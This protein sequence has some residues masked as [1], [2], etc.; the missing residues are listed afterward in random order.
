MK[1]N[2]RNHRGFK[3][4]QA[5]KVVIDKNNHFNG[6]CIIKHE[7]SIFV[8][9]MQGEV[10]KGFAY[11]T[12]ENGLVFKGEYDEGKKVQGS[13]FNSSMD[14]VI[15]EGEWLN[16]YYHGRGRL[17]CDQNHVY[18]G[19]FK[20][21]LFDGQGEMRWSNGDVYSGSFIEHTRSG[22]GKLKFANGD[23]YEGQFQLGKPEGKGKYKWAHGAE[24]E[25]NFRKG[26]I[27]TLEFSTL[28]QSGINESV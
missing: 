6:F 8:G 27:N 2:L 18:E 9:S 1:L 19:E 12:Y 11:T 24:Y 16:D 14:K 4:D 20:Q 13:V 26:E 28:Q 23:C 10:K 17:C 3:L 15:Y 7:Q 22:L 21:G 25:G 5:T